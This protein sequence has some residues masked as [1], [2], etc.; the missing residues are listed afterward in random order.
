MHLCLVQSERHI[1][2]TFGTLIGTTVTNVQQLKATSVQ[3]S[4]YYC[5]SI[6][7]PYIVDLQRKPIFH[8]RWM[9]PK[10]ELKGEW[11]WL[12]KQV[13]KNITPTE[14]QAAMWKKAFFCYQIGHAVIL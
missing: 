9:R 6:D 12:T 4:L 2:N 7:K 1:E 14:W 8:G 11:T 13:I 3:L 10:L 5:T